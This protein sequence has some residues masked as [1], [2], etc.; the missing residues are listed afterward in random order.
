MLLHAR[1]LPL[2]ELL[3]PLY[4]TALANQQIFMVFFTAL[5]AREGSLLAAGQAA[6]KVM[7]AKPWS[8]L[9]MSRPPSG[10]TAR[11]SRATPPRASTSF[12][13]KAKHFKPV[14]WCRC[15]RK[16]PWTDRKSL[17]Y[18][19]DKYPCCFPRRKGKTQPSLGPYS[20][21]PNS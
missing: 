11:L 18:W 15:Q 8:S 14:A 2:L 10:R 5:A 9:V 4:A 21:G 13:L 7:A 3:L 19:G 16:Q 1:P 20:L 6:R 17:A 12:I